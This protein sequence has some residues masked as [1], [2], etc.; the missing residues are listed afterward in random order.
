LLREGSIAVQLTAIKGDTT[1][2]AEDQKSEEFKFR[3]D[4]RLT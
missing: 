1:M 3:L 4:G 2:S